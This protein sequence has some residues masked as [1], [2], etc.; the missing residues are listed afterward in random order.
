MGTIVTIATHIGV[1]TGC[2]VIFE[3]TRYDKGKGKPVT[4]TATFSAEHASTECTLHVWQGEDG[5][6]MARNGSITLNGQTIVTQK[7]LK[8]SPGYISKPVTVQLN[9]VMTVNLKGKAGVFLK[10]KIIRETDPDDLSITI[11]SPLDGETVDG[12]SVTV[13]GSFTA[14]S[15]EVSVMVNDEYAEVSGNNFFANNIPLT[16]GENTI[17]AAV[18]EPEGRKALE[19]II[20]QT[21]T[22]VRPVRLSSNISSGVPP[23]AVNFAVATSVPFPINMYQMD[24]DGDGNMDYTADNADNVSHTYNI[25][26]LYEV[27]ALVTD[28]QGR[29]INMMK[30]NMDSCDT[31]GRTGRPVKRQM[32]GNGPSL[33]GEGR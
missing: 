28:D 20:V 14:L 8:K 15:D 18:I 33:D 25:D 5:E 10:V 26:G 4:Y 29:E 17:S 9:N 24:F 12:R 19:T 2:T 27:Y 13:W 1:C 7:E 32:V 3:T 23:L 11:I 30:T 21:D 31:K 16:A 6:N 22:R